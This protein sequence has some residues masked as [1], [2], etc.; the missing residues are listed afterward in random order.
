MIKTK[1]LKRV[2]SYF[3]ELLFTL[4]CKIIKFIFH[5][6]KDKDRRIVIGF[7]GRHGN[8]AAL[9]R[10]M[11]NYKIFKTYWV[12]DVKNFNHPKSYFYRDF[13]KIPLF[14]KTD[15]WITTHGP[16]PIPINDWHTSSYRFELWH[17]LLYKGWLD[18][19]KERMR[20]DFNKCTIK[21]ATS[22]FIK[23]IYVNKI[24]IKENIVKV[25]GYPRTDI[26]FD[27]S[28]D[29]KV[30]L[31]EIN[32]S[33]HKK[34]ILYAPTY[35]Q[36]SDSEKNLFP[37]DSIE[38]L[39][40]LCKMCLD[41][42]LNLIIRTHPNWKKGWDVSFNRIIEN[43]EDVLYLPVADYPNTENLLCITDVLITDWSSIGNDFIILNR[44]LIFLDIEDPF[45]GEFLL[46]PHDRVG[47]IVSNSEEFFSSL[48]IS[49]TNPADFQQTFNFQRQKLMEKLYLHIDGKSSKRCIREILLLLNN[50]T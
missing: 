11:Q 4:F 42:N 37:W 40:K 49:T 23:D 17:G 38:T 10:E 3:R 32:L 9:Y 16:Y 7:C 33:R 41:K 2:L 8:A 30:I 21:S 34:T 36:D 50:N 39:D 1:F 19:E 5:Y 27:N 20:D 24:G 6:I 15:I 35:E 25:T 46:E 48:D 45:G 12:H 14:V 13:T 18:Y 28:F 43:Y 26:I 22:E 29:R 47:Y 31:S 44:P